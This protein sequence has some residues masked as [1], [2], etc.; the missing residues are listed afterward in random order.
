MRSLPTPVKQA[1]SDQELEEHIKHCG[2][3]MEQ[4]YARWEAS[5][6]FGDRGE[7]DGWRI[8]M[9]R[10]IADRSAVQVAA[11]EAERGLTL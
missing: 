2:E 8:T 1:L 5:G 7:A 10:A 3:L 6:C 9:E 4:A 11:L